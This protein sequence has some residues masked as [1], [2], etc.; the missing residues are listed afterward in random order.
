MAA[1]WPL[2]A[3]PEV[4]PFLGLSMGRTAALGQQR[5]RL[6]L[7]GSI[8][9]LAPVAVAAVV[10]SPLVPWRMRAAM[11]GGRWPARIWLPGLLAVA[12]TA[13]TAF[14]LL[15]SAKHLAVAA[16]GRMPQG[17]VMRAVPVVPME[18]VAVAAARPSTARRRVLAETAAQVSW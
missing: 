12:Q 17:P 5:A 13:A 16:A 15:H 8:L 4:V 11:A 6:E 9:A 1:D 2:V 14:H 10:G 7:M 18:R 3:P